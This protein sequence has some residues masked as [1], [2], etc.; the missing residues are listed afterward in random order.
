VIILGVS[1]AIGVVVLNFFPF[2]KEQAAQAAI[3]CEACGTHPPEPG[4]GR[5]WEVDIPVSTYSRVNTRHGNLFTAI[6]IVSWSGRGPDMNMMLYHNSA[7]AISGYSIADVVGFDLGP[8]WSLSYSDHLRFDVYPN[9]TRVTVVA[10]DGTRD[11]FTWNG[12]IWV[13][14]WGVHDQ[15]TEVSTNVW[16]LKHKDQSYHEFEHLGSSLFARLKRVVD[17][18]DK[19]IRV[20]Y[21]SGILQEIKDASQRNLKFVLSTTTGRLNWIEDPIESNE[22][23]GSTLETRYWTFSYTSTGPLERIHDYRMNHD[24]SFYYSPDGRLLFVTDTY[25][26]T[27]DPAVWYTYGYDSGGRLNY[28]LDPVGGL[29]QGFTYTCEKCPYGSQGQF[30]SLDLYTDYT[31][32]R[33]NL[34]RYHFWVEQG[35]SVPTAYLRDIWSPTTQRTFVYDGD[36]NLLRYCDR[37]SGVFN[38]WNSSY[39]S[40]GNRLT[41][42]DPLG[43]VQN[44]TYDAFNR[45][46]Y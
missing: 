14:H 11:V 9:P 41:L 13:P 4:P 28:V 26:Q 37:P 21:V 2:P 16:Q 45:A 15:L 43:H 22:P 3:E 12:T 34:W 27:G 29:T 6:P 25:S 23:S 32:R 10:D 46:S 35:V 31:D 30:W 38:C 8:G 42:T 17:A 39:D 7:N 44:W 1:L 40:Q 5:S 18:T 36:R 19:E 33:G 24:N 20:T